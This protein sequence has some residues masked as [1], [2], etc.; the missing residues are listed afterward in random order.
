MKAMILQHKSFG[1]LD[2]ER[3]EVTDGGQLYKYLV[4]KDK[5]GV[6]WHDLVSQFGPFDQYIAVDEAGR[7]V[8]MET[9]P[10][11]MQIGGFNVIGLKTNSDFAWTRGPGGTVYGKIWNGSAIVE[12]EPEPEPIPDEISRRQFFQHL[13]VIG[14]ISKDEALAAMQGGVIPA[15]LQAIIDQ[16]PT[17]DD[18]FN[19]QM[20]VVGA[21][22]F[23]R[24]HWLTDVV[25]QA[26]QWTIDQRD[27]FWRDASKI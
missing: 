6:E 7:V 16:L 19:A 21:Q 26:M 20:F 12:P 25:R 23:N 2:P 22:N 11:A 15:P 24:L 18:K 3:V 9:N 1:I 5:N 4:F 17:D 10:D 13:A 27:H 14:I 8:S